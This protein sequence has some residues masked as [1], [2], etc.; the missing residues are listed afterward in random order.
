[1]YIYICRAYFNR[2][3]IAICDSNSGNCYKVFILYRR[4]AMCLFISICSVLNQLQDLLRKQVL[5]WTP[6]STR[7]LL[8]ANDI[9]SYK[10]ALFINTIH[11]GVDVFASK[12]HA[13][14]G[15]HNIHNKYRQTSII[16]ILKKLPY[17]HIITVF[18]NDFSPRTEDQVHY[19]HSFLI[20]IGNNKTKHAVCCVYVMAF[21]SI[22]M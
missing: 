6:R 21:M 13:T 20:S 16:I 3:R 9:A 17:C 10:S 12:N 11:H 22:F 7:L 14:D 18:I 5:L 15:E 8:L 19:I 4:F 2:Y 1:M